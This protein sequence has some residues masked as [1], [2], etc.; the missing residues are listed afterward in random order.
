M[1]EF[2]RFDP[3]AHSLEA[4]LRMPALS[5]GASEKSASERANSLSSG[6]AWSIVG[7]VPLGPT[8]RRSAHNQRVT[9]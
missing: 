2:Y 4:K 8:V 9:T 7:H 1:T 6:T 3:M 5:A